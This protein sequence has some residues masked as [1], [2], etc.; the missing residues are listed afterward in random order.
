MFTTAAD[1]HH[2]RPFGVLAVFTA[3]FTAFFGRTVA[4]AVRAFPLVLFSHNGLFFSW[5]SKNSY[6]NYQGI[7]SEWY[8]RQSAIQSRLRFDF[9]LFQ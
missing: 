8:A 5:R 6:L 1:F 3:I 9:M 4:G 2:L 7:Q